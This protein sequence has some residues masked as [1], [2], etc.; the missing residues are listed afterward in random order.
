VI[1]GSGASQDRAIVEV[2]AANVDDAEAIARVHS[3]S[4]RSAYRAILP[5][6][7]LAGLE[8]NALAPRWARALRQGIGAHVACL[9]RESGSR[10]SVRD[11]EPQSPI[12]RGDAEVRAFVTWGAHSD[13]SWHG[14]AGEVFMLYVDPESAGRGLGRAL[15]DRATAELGARGARWIVVRVLEANAPARRFYERA[16]LELDG[17]RSVDE[18][19][20]EPRDVVRYARVLAPYVDLRA[21]WSSARA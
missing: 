14:H 19:G 21:I 8:P 17:H 16:G 1:R 10:R 7:Y 9:G 11:A 13:P 20:G 6:R 4:W 12:E 3:R 18:V 2:R 15:L 5:P